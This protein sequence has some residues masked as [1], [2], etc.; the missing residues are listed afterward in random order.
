MIES[1]VTVL[2]L[3]DDSEH[4]AS[5]KS[6][7]RQ[8]AQSAVFIPAFNEADF[9]KKFSWLPATFL[10]VRAE[11]LSDGLQ[12]F[13]EDVQAKDRSIVSR[14]QADDL[15]ALPVTLKIVYENNFRSVSILQAE[16]KSSL[17]EQ[18][19]QALSSRR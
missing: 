7:V 2:V 5:I 9:R 15:N 16:R 3:T 13:L 10:I 6:L 14:F 8:R 17:A 18:K 1:H 12:Q 11:L 4:F 19:R